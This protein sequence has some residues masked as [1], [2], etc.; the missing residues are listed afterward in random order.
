MA[1]LHP[2]DSAKIEQ[3]AAC[4]TLPI[5]CREHVYVFFV[6]GMDPLNYANMTGVRDYVNELGFGKTYLGQMYHAAY[7]NREIHRIAGEDPEA[8]FV[9]IGFSFG[10]NLVRDLAA[11]AKKD[12]IS[13]DLL[14]Y[15]GG[16]TVRSQY[17]A[18]LIDEETPGAMA[19]L[20]LMFG[21]EQAPWNA[22]GF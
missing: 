10:A 3:T 13:I 1:Y 21:A 19:R 8:R 17:L 7:F 9:L 12:D 20:H 11:S 5:G 2:V 18:G 4:L 6:H 14:I 22:T 16:N 15:L